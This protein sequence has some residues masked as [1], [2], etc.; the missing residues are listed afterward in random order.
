MSTCSPSHLRQLVVLAELMAFLVAVGEC[1]V[2][3]ASECE[4][5]A[6]AVGAGEEV[7]LGV[8]VDALESQEVM[9][10]LVA[11]M[12]IV[13][14]GKLFVLELKL[15]VIGCRLL[16]FG[17]SGGLLLRLGNRLDIHDY[18]SD[19]FRLDVAPHVAPGGGR[20]HFRLDNAFLGASDFVH[21]GASVRLT[22]YVVGWLHRVA[23]IIF[24]L[25]A[26]G[27][28]R[29]KLIGR[30]RFIFFVGS[31]WLSAFV[32]RELVVL[33]LHFLVIYAYLRLKKR[34]A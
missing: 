23:A 11:L 18:L 20:G 1:I 31:Q 33:S 2:K 16:G 17:E 27:A 12:M 3:I 9:L 34:E 32:A 29:S 8:V 30:L 24:L 13:I 25:Y 21:V 7:K 22:L 10:C 15:L 6:A 26:T 19:W 5:H 4:E 28:N 14:K